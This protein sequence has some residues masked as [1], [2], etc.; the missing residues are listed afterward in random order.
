MAGSNG[1]RQF[2]VVCLC[3]GLGVYFVFHAVSGRHGLEARA[4]LQAEEQRLA[5]EL[6]GL[7]A[8]RDALAHDNALLGAH[9]NLD[10]LDEQA[11]RVL[12]FAA[13]EDRILIQITDTLRA[14]P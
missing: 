6:A 1:P 9:P 5:R 12:N 11:R 13:P 2:L 14:K 10:M 8:Q 4:Q 7:E 3:L